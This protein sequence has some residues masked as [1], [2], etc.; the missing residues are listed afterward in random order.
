MMRPHRLRRNSVSGAPV[1]PYEHRGADIRKLRLDSSDDFQRVVEI[2]RGEP[3]VWLR[4]LLA[5][6]L[7]EHPDAHA[8]PSE[9][10]GELEE[11]MECRVT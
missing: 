6:R 4:K 3:D 7:L 9:L 1:R 8:A 10:R 5:M 2:F 11:A